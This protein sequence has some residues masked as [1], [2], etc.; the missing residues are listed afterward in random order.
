[1]VLLHVTRI[2]GV[3]GAAW[4][5]IG[6]GFGVFGMLSARREWE[7]AA[8]GLDVMIYGGGCLIGLVAASVAQ[9]GLWLRPG[10]QRTNFDG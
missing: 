4:C 9:I 5:A 10:Q 2:A 8:S 3:L 1:M 7:V 6:I